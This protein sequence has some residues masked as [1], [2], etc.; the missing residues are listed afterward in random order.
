MSQEWNPE[1][2][3]NGKL[4]ESIKHS[5]NK[6]AQHKL[7]GTIPGIG[8]VKDVM[9]FDIYQNVILVFGDEFIAIL[10]KSEDIKE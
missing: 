8:K 5:F 1:A 3:Y 4:S 6:M 9:S 10:S 7:T 2:I